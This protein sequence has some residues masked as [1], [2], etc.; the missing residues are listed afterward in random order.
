MSTV[1][2]VEDSKTFGALLVRL[3]ERE[4]GR[5]AVWVKSHEECRAT[6][7]S[8]ERSFDAALLDLNLPDAPDGQVVDL[9]LSH[10][11]P[12]IVFTGE[13]SDD[14]R[15]VI[16][17]KHIVDYVL[18][19]SLH[20]LEYV[21]TLLK[22]ILRNKGLRTLVV[23]D[24]KMARNH[25]SALLTAHGYDVVEASN[26][27]EALYIIEKDPEIRLVLTD[28][29]MPDMDGARLTKA[30]REVTRRESLFI[31]GMSSQG[32]YLTSVAMLK[33]GANDF[34]TRPFQAE[35]F[36][37]R[38]S[39]NVDMLNMIEDLTGMA[40]R[41]FLTGLHNRKYLFE[42][43]RQLLANQLRGNL[44]LTAAI[45]DIDHFKKINDTHGH[46]AGDAVLRHFASLLRERFR[47]SDVIARFGGEEFCVLSVN[48][49]P[50]RAFGVFDAFRRDV[51]D[52]PLNHHGS[53]ISCTVSIGVHTGRVSTFEALLKAADDLL[54][55]A[56]QE[57]RNR[58]AAS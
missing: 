1:L 39:Q 34:I 5:E 16:W 17:S 27:G 41:D 9:V 32:S 42:S 21:A 14:L 11:V 33:S 53:V 13:L 7:E 3:V 54:Y 44:S 50:A 15:D 25:A 45:M 4:T 26:G 6:L 57:G 24:S 10:A 22:R 52:K 46:D 19:E 38:I 43:G 40:N 29:N 20:N 31:I 37:C 48:M 49:D 2:I 58:V 30:I 28:F 35:E 51:A 55:K 36:Y 12:S 8:G 23:D 47:E 18:K 56:K